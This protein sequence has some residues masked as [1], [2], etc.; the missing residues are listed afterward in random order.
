[1]PYTHDALAGVTNQAL[2]L[3]LKL[4][5]CEFQRPA[6]LG[7]GAD[8]VLRNAGGDLGVDLDGDHHVG[9]HPLLLGSGRNNDPG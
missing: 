3:L 7:D 8:H 1:M 2:L 4:L 6:V 9:V 5:T